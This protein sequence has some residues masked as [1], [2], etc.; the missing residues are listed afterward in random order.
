MQQVDLAAYDPLWEEFQ[1]NL[2]TEGG[3]M[4]RNWNLASDLAKAYPT[5]RDEIIAL[6]AELSRIGPNDR[7]HASTWREE[8]ERMAEECILHRQRADIAHGGLLLMRDRLNELEA[9]ARDAI[10]KTEA[11]QAE[12]RAHQSA[13]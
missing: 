12:I 4:M 1:G 8:A 2:G 11:L 3:S 9:T 6:R 13:P 7:I 5:L 10:A